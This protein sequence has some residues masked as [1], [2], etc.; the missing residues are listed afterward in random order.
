MS[1]EP[2]DNAVVPRFPRGVRLRF[3]E[4]MDA[5]VLLAPERIFKLDDI[6]KAI[7]ERVDGTAS[8]GAI[9]EDLATTFKT[10][11]AQVRGDVETLLRTIAD[12]RLL[13]L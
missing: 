7:M 5:W 3:H 8:L 2:L 1:T 11:Q 12:K 6:A 4:P 10:D 13:E 9:V